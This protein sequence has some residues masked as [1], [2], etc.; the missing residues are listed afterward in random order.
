MEKWT[1]IVE[2]V[3]KVPLAFVIA[4]LSSL[5]LILFA[6]DQYAKILSIDTFRDQYRVF[7]GPA[8]ILFF[9]FTIAK[10]YTAF[11]DAYAQRSNVKTR[12]KTLHSLTPEEKGYLVQYIHKRANSIYVGM[13][14]GIMAGLQRKGITYRA[15]NMG[16]LVDG[17][18]F[19]L[20][21]WA[22]EYLESNP[23]LL[24]GH[25]GKPLTPRQK[26]HLDR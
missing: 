20:Q 16:S 14:D 13:D 3:R 18:A 1:S 2:Y 26:L 24:D 10:I 12:R 17:F 15:A 23:N 9:A 25:V 22:R 19:N 4:V 11:A 8:F 5:S 7:L 6:P 21:P